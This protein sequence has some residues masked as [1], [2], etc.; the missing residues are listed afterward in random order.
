MTTLLIIVLIADPPMVEW[1]A[2]P[3]QEMLAVDC[4]GDINGNG[5][6]DVVAI[7]PYGL[8]SGVVCLDGY[9][10]EQLWDAPLL[11][12]LPEPSALCAIPDI[13][14]DGMCD[15]VYGSGPQEVAS[16]QA[17]RALS[18][19]DGSQI[20]SRLVGEG[21]HAVAWISAPPD[22]SPLVHV[23]RG[24]TGYIQ[25][26]C[27]RAADGDSLWLEWGAG[28]GDGEIS[29]MPDF[30]GNG[31]GEAAISVDRGSVSS[32]FCRI[33][34]G[35]TGSYIYT[36]PTCY[37]GRMDVC[38]TPM[39]IAVGQFGLLPELRVEHIAT[40]DTLWSIDYADVSWGLQ[41]LEDI[42]ED[43]VPLP[44]LAGV[45][46][47]E[48]Q[49]YYGE[50][51]EPGYTDAF[52]QAIMSLDTYE[53]G[54]A[55]CDLAVLTTGTFHT[56]E[57]FPYPVGTGSC[58]L[59]GETGTDMC[60]LESDKY[61]TPLVAVAMTGDGPG[62]CVIATSWG[63]GVQEDP[64]GQQSPSVR[65]PVN[66]GVGGVS[67][68]LTGATG[69]LSILDLSGREVQRLCSPG[70]GVVF[71]PLPAGVYLVVDRKTGS[72]LGRAVVIS[73]H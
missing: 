50:T 27:L 67:L 39:V 11:P 64:P 72:L 36:T 22:S 19:A 53:V 70:E 13:D 57:L 4:I 32:G 18:G 15:L 58:D 51:G 43:I 41:Y 30:T 61:P 55:S 68:V 20:W 45:D 33:M 52:S 25:F 3:G 37:F 31:Y 16:D 12:G 2:M 62:L 44:V 26:M 6:E 54:S 63:L 60:F 40:G 5:T 34:D 49:L 47:G 35:L 10:G 1:T 48:I 59:P 29:T 42:P 69:Q 8:G 66:P 9:T 23:S 56:V 28:T 7:P 65:L 38:D 21:M 71:V 46:G 14:G 24:D 17:L 73:N